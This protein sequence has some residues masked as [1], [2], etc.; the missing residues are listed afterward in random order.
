MGQMG[1]IMGDGHLVAE[2]SQ[3]QERQKA[4]ETPMSQGHLFAEEGQQKEEQRKSNRRPKRR[5]RPRAGKSPRKKRRR[6]W[7]KRSQKVSE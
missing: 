2:E 7:P 4:E 5:Q 1:P 3:T 6:S